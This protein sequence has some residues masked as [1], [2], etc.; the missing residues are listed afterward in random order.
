MK[1]KYLSLIFL[2]V[3]DIITIKLI[4]INSN[5]PSTILYLSSII[6]VTAFIFAI[7]LSNLAFFIMKNWNKRIF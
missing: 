2:I 4:E 6:F 1:I 5:E 3:L 7:L